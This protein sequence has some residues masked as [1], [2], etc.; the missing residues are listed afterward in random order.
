MSMT[1]CHV[2]ERAQSKDLFLG[3]IQY[4]NGL[5]CDRKQINHS[6]HTDTS[7]CIYFIEKTNSEELQLLTGKLYEIAPHASQLASD[8]RSPGSHD[9]RAQSVVQ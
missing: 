3:S 8:H 2:D 9:I 5:F 6:L 4:N 1:G 7:K